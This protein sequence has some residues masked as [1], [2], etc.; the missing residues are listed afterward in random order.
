VN[1]GGESITWNSALD[2]YDWSV[3]LPDGQTITG[4]SPS[5]REARRDM[6]TDWRVRG[7]QPRFV[8]RLPRGGVD[9]AKHDLR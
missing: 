2:R 7:E 4:H 1:P 8:L 9:G 6:R 5:E 3:T